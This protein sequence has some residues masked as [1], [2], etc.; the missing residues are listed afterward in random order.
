MQIHITEEMV[1]AS[2]EAMRQEAIKDGHDWG[3]VE[4]AK[5]EEHARFREVVRAML[6]AAANT[7][8]N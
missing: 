7:L 1:N 4:N 3:H 5:P 2:L 6:Q 8:S